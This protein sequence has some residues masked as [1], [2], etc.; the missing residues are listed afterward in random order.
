MPDEAYA[1]L[2]SLS[3]ATIQFLGLE[4]SRPEDL[5]LTLQIVPPPSIRPSNF[6][7]ESKVRS[8][9]DLTVALQD[10]V[11]SNI[12]LENIWSEM[13]DDVRK[14]EV[15]L[16]DKISKSKITDFFQAWDKLQV[17]TSGLVNHTI[18]KTIA[19]RMGLLPVV[20]STNKRKV[21]DIKTRLCGKKG[22]LR[23][24]LS[25]KRVDQSGRSV[26]S[27]DASH[28]IYELGVPE[29]IMNKLTFPETV[30]SW[31]KDSLAK[32]IVRGAFVENG[33]LAVRLPGSDS[34][35]VIWLPVLDLEAR[36]DLAASLGIGY[37]VERHLQDGDFV[38]FNRQPS[39]WK[40]SLMAFQA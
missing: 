9:N 26:I 38:L 24:N 31:N 4:V 14:A 35:H 39:L 8:E 11:R 6:V 16:Y 21:I 36:T 12:E 27:P 1:I 20:T 23:G 25:G 17:M 29:C 10:I 32:C 28:D 33:A 19:T 13:P 22:R 30:N 5:L 18:K 2:A 3:Q 34:E 15:S 40:A 7:G 37:T